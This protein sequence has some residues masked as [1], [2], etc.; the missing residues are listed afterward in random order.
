MVHNNL[1]F[2]SILFRRARISEQKK[3]KIM[4]LLS[5]PLYPDKIL[6]DANDPYVNSRVE[7]RKINEAWWRTKSH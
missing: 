6:V 2:A 5:Q 3:S 1:N 4:E 7:L